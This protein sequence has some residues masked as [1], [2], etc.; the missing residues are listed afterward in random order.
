MIQTLYTS[1]EHLVKV[2]GHLLAPFPFKR[3]IREGCP[4]SGQLYS[5]RIEPFVCLMRRRL[6][7]MVVPNNRLFLIFSAYADD[8]LVLP[9]VQETCKPFMIVSE[10]TQQH[11][12]RQ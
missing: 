4:L 5:L 2:N 11:R 7:G 12:L 1:A 10:S 8:A 9:A 3:G 6:T